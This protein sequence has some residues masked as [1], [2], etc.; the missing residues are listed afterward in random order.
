[1]GKSK[2]LIE[3]IQAELNEAKEKKEETSLQLNQ[4]YEYGQNL[5]RILQ[6]KDRT[7]A[8]LEQRSRSSFQDLQ[9]K[10]NVM[11]EIVKGK[12]NEIRTRDKEISTLKDRTRKAK[13]N[14]AEELIG[15][16]SIARKFVELSDTM[17]LL[18]FQC[19]QYKRDFLKEREER[20]NMA[21]RC[22]G[23]DVGT[24]RKIVSIIQQLSTI[25][26]FIPAYG[27]KDMIDCD[28]AT[29]GPS[30]PGSDEDSSSSTDEDEDEEEIHVEEST[31]HLQ[32]LKL[33]HEIMNECN[34][35]E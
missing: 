8:D 14:G 10:D 7:I 22:G 25:T 21:G 9:M 20:Q 16:R 6:E 18:R 31:E 17:K 19:T 24:R 28:I 23:V 29:D 35:D 34:V 5:L 11:A 2:E 13:R 1:M 33:C 30:A 15:S 27:G 26:N 32:M 4:S 3:R 12:D